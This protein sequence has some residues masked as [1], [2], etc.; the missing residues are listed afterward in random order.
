MPQFFPSLCSIYDVV[1]VTNEIGERIPTPPDE[2][3]PGTLSARWENIPCAIGDSRGVRQRQI[4]EVRTDDADY[5]SK[6][7]VIM[8]GGH[9]PA[10]TTKMRAVVDGVTYDIRAV[11]PSMIGSHTE[12]IVER[13]T[14]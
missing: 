14:I 12:L 13:I 3:L 2:Q 9:Y 6:L 1:E 7:Q 8:L 5:T 11:P 4:S 10:I